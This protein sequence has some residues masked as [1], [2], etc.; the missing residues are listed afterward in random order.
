MI[1]FTDSIRSFI[2][3]VR[4]ASGVDPL[5]FGLLFYG[6][7]PLHMLC[8]AWLVRNIRTKRSIIFPALLSFIFSACSVLFITS[9][10]ITISAW[11]YL[12]PSSAAAVGIGMLWATFNPPFTK[13]SRRRL[14]RRK[15]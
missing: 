2:A 12:V 15:G 1:R 3:S 6:S 8:I 7:I 5:L 9:T 4:Y 10:G 14:R 13:V 11:I